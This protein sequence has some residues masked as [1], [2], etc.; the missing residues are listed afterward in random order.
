MTAM[1][2]IEYGP[3]PSMLAE[4]VGDVFAGLFGDAYGRPYPASPSDALSVSG[5]VSVSGGWFGEVVICCSAP[6]ALR[7]AAELFA[8]SPDDVADDDVRDVVGEF[9]NVIGGNVKS[10]MPGPSALS[11]PSTSLCGD[12]ERPGEVEALRIDLTWQD[13]P[14]RVSIWTMPAG[15]PTEGNPS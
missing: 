7:A 5:R 4:I 13:E 12:V 6:L 14:L 11:L 9:A 3:D 8:M 1:A 15:K 2:D 10:V